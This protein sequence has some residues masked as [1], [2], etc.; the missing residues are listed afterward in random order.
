MDGGGAVGECVGLKAKRREGGREGGKKGE[1]GR[2][3]GAMEG[4]RSTNVLM[5]KQFPQQQQ[6]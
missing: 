5:W 4:R 3:E 2:N 6:M 1:K